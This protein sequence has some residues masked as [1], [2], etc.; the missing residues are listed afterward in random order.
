MSGKL[1]KR[2]PFPIVTGG[3]VLLLQLGMSSDAWGWDFTVSKFAMATASYTGPD[4][5]DVAGDRV[6]VGFNNGT[7]TDGS[8]GKS[9][10]IVEYNLDGTVVKTFSVTGHNDGLRVNPDDGLVWAIQNEDGNP[11]LAIIDPD[12]GKLATFKL[13]EPH[14]GG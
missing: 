13:P 2:S 12:S 7:A 6:F 11:N 14:G 8:D 5:I 9:S 10:T 4:S 1:G 3:L